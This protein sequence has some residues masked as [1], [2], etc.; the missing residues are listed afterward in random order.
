MYDEC[1]KNRFFFAFA[2]FEVP[3]FRV[4][5]FALSLA[6]PDFLCQIL[7]YQNIFAAFCTHTNT[8]TQ[9]EGEKE[10]E[11]IERKIRMKESERE[12]TESRK[13]RQRQEYKYTES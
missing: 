6:L 8:L 7:W 1:I 13:V 9:K 2:D 5:F 11:E 12:D 4:F 3:S 10:G